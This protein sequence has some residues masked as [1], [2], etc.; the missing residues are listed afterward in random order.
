MTF[1]CR[2]P[3]AE[4]LPSIS[5]DCGS[6]GGWLWNHG[7]QEH[8]AIC[9]TTQYLLLMPPLFPGCWDIVW[10]K[11]TGVLTPLL[12][13]RKMVSALL[14]SANIA[15][16]CIWLVKPISYPEPN[17]QGSMGTSGLKKNISSL[18][19]V[20][21]RRRWKWIQNANWPFPSQQVHVEFKQWDFIWMGFDLKAELCEAKTSWRIS[22]CLC[23][24]YAPGNGRIKAMEHG[25]LSAWTFQEFSC[26][27][28]VA[29]QFLFLF[30]NSFFSHN[31]PIKSFTWLCW[32]WKIFVDLFVSLCWISMTCGLES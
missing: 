11:P 16:K 12:T 27:V 32:S 19:S 28:I 31:T 24:K 18:S 9:P 22:L 17:L 5:L 13:S 8:T 26:S 10:Q 23:H 14:L 1:S 3:S 4:L 25:D 21:S 2:N 30:T 6:S 15:F 20:P 29:D 7:V